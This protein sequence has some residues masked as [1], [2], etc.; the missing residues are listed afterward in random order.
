MVG[1]FSTLF[2][3]GL[4]SILIGIWGGLSGLELK[5]LTTTDGFPAS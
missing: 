1:T 4:H 5:E 2:E 3:K